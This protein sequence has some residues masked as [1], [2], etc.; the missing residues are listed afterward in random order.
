MI[1]CGICNNNKNLYYRH[2]LNINSLKIICIN[3]LNDNFIY[4]DN[5]LLKDNI[6]LNKNKLIKR[7]KSYKKI[8]FFN[9]SKI[10][11]LKLK[12][13]YQYA[14]GTYYKVD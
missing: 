9:Y 1:K 3:C 2:N 13:L 11:Q 5:K 6:C 4:I 10:Y 7:K 14:D 12:Y 8:N